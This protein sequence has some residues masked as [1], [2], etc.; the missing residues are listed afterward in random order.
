MLASVL[1]LTVATAIWNAPR[2]S[3]AN[4][5]PLVA[6][7]PIGSF[8]HIAPAQA[9]RLVHRFMLTNLS[10]APIRLVEATTSCRC[11]VPAMSHAPIQPGA[12][13][14][15]DVK[16]NWGG[17][18]GPQR[19]E[20]HLT[21]DNAAQR[22]L[23]LAV[24]AD[25]HQILIASPA[26]IDFGVCARGK[27][28]V[29]RL[30]LYPEAGAP[31]LCVS[32]A[33]A[34]CTFLNISREPSRQSAAGL[35]G[36]QEQTWALSLAANAPLGAH[37]VWAKFNT[38]IPGRPQLAVPVLCRVVSP[39]EIKPA[40]CVLRPD[41]GMDQQTFTISG[42][43]PIEKAELVADRGFEN[44]FSLLARG[45]SVP[46]T[47]GYVTS[48]SVGFSAKGSPPITHCKLLVTGGGQTA[49]AAIL[50]TR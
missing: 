33:V 45:K 30:T 22:K 38:N 46:T 42:A 26:E 29:R 24:Q 4:T 34:D 47:Q 19:E 43:S 2:A 7:N 9:D 1:A 5:G 17:R 44:Y 23:V 49:E 48:M 14:P 25:I 11:T 21:T 20:I 35:G 41:G 32:S 31:P 40:A 15:V 8:G 12:S 18:I 37:R 6:D 3:A 39:I 16:V 13:L 28:A 50:V 27:S 36:E 10:A